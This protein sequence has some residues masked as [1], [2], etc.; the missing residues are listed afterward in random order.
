[1]DATIKTKAE[2]LGQLL[3]ESSVFQRLETA[4]AAMKERSAAQL[5]LRD[6]VA[7]QQRLQQKSMAGHEISE[8]EMGDLERSWQIVSMN[9]YVREYL[10]AEREFADTWLGVMGIL[11]QA[12]GLDA[13]DEAEAEE[14]EGSAEESADSN[15][16]A[17]A[18]AKSRLWVPGGK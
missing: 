12:V 17:A 4:R 3:A 11:S 13:P 8:A 18:K 6:F 7:K 1:V 16:A 14:A 5:M 15:E 2:E 9:P 10:Q